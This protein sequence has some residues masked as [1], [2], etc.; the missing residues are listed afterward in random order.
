MIGQ[1]ETLKRTA[2]EYKLGTIDGIG[3][4]VKYGT[5]D[6]NNPEI[7]YI[8]CKGGIKPNEDKKDYS[9]EIMSLKEDFLFSVK[10]IINN[11]PLFNNKHICSI[12]VSDGIS[13]RKTSRLKYDVFLKPKIKKEISE[14]KEDI[15]DIVKSFNSVVLQ[16]LID[17]NIHLE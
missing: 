3:I 2:K 6:K 8:R 9:E 14:Y 15:I 1:N 16:L 5:L 11:S 12:E 10:E 4:N 7:I 13:P 17:R